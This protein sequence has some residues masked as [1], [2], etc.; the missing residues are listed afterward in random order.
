MKAINLICET[1]FVTAHQI[2]QRVRNLKKNQCPIY[3]E[4]CYIFQRDTNAVKQKICEGVR[5]LLKHIK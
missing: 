5:R 3:F 1:G 4:K 2:M